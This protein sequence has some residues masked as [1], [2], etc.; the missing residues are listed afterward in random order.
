M[1]I[2]FTDTEWEIL[3]H[4]LDEE[5]CIADALTDEEDS[6]YDYEE[7][8]A[9]VCLLW[10]N[11]PRIPDRLDDPLTRTI[12]QDCCEGCTFFCGMEDA[13]AT[14]ELSRGKALSYHR[15]VFTLE[16]K[17]GVKVTTS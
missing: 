7:V 14:E 9:R 2:E 15:A 11:G 3:S 13:V 16:R 4:R 10:A 1:G 6:E 8:M 5:S 17:L 12:L